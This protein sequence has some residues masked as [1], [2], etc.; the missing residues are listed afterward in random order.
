MAE[1]VDRPFWAKTFWYDSHGGDFGLLHPDD[2][3]TRGTPRPAFDAYRAFISA[4]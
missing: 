3:P 4:H 1:M 2:S